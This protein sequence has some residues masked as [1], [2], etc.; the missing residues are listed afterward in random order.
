MQAPSPPMPEYDQIVK[1]NI[2]IKKTSKHNYRITFS[3]IGKFLVYQVW[4]KDNTDLN[5]NRSVFYTSAKKWVD[6]FN[7]INK[8]LKQ[9]KKPLFTPTTVIE[10][11][12]RDDNYAFVIHKAYLNSH[13]Q[14]VF[15]V[16]TKEIKIESSNTS[17]KNL[18][19]IPCGKFNNV[20][21]DI[22]AVDD[23]TTI[24]S[25]FSME[26]DEKL[27]GGGHRY[28]NVTNPKTN[29]PLTRTELVSIL[30]KYN[31]GYEI[32]G[33]N[34]FITTNGGGFSGGPMTVEYDTFFSS[35]DEALKG[36]VSTIK[37]QK[38][39]QKICDTGGFMITIEDWNQ[40][41]FSITIDDGQI[42][43][44]LMAFAPGLFKEPFPVALVDVDPT[45]LTS[46]RFV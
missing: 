34:Y 26:Y 27:V 33:S 20:R 10:M 17:S 23:D 2:T 38:C 24:L 37:L 25:N 29:K 40:L 8:D 32:I 31:I 13:G 46:I 1:G 5:S 22:D 4:D 16:S 42:P 6:N 35:V 12:D 7:D 43:S 18:I 39:N 30:K 28:K 11:E 44:K 15:T 21:F 14:V 36:D 9:K 45:K 41:I 3:K 19:K